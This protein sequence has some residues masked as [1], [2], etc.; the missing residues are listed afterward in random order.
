VS[1][2]V[3]FVGILLMVICLIIY[4]PSDGFTIRNNT[5]LGIG[6]GVGFSLLLCFFV[7]LGLVINH[8]CKHDVFCI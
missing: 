6:L 2:V 7:V 3:V 4:T 8:S 5:T 1:F